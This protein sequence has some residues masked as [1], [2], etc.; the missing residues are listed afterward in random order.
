MKAT[1][2]VIKVTKVSMEQL[3]KLQAAGYIVVIVGGAK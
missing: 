3:T 2:R 1:K